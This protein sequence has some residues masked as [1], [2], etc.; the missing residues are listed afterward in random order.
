MNPFEVA[1]TLGIL[2]FLFF[3]WISL[4]LSLWTHKKDTE[5][6]DE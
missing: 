1:Y 4:I 2:G 3:L 5:E 6:R